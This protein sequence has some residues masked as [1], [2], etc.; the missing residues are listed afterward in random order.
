M[1]SKLPEFFRQ[2]AFYRYHP[3]FQRRERDYKLRLASNFSKSRDLLNSKPSV[4][5]EI[6]RKTFTGKDNN[7]V[8]WHSQADVVSWLRNR[9]KAVSASL[10]NLW[11]SLEPVEARFATF[12]ERLADIGI[13]ASGT[14]LAIAST[15]VMTHSATD[16][17]PVKVGAFRH[18]LEMLGW[19]DLSTKPSA[20]ER[21]LYAR[22]FLDFILKQAPKFKVE[23]RDRLD[24]Q[25]I[26]WCI[27]G[28]WRDTK[29][30]KSWK[31]DVEK[32]ALAEST[33]YHADIVE[34]DAEPNGKRRTP[35]EKLT[36]VK[37][38]RGQGKFRDGVIEVWGNCELS[39]CRDLD[40]LRASHI[41][42]WKVCNDLQRLD[43]FNGLLLSPNFDAVF[44]AGLISFSND[45]TILISKFLTSGD[46][47]ALG[48]FSHLKLRSL[49]KSH[50][51]Y[52]EH[53]RK[54]VFDKKLKHRG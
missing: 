14:Q 9:P 28:G 8:D 2:A 37:A 50:L 21:Y 13:T 34:L 3:L 18:G 40:L 4:A 45:G 27:G 48:L 43:K 5:L 53:H 6:F 25:G 29:V 10:R 49:R 31:N 38:R 35:T 36:L 44:D 24:A 11:E 16:F 41:M 26:L 32:R 39:G 54:H 12:T 42:P 1:N 33:S 7:I 22:S 30:P 52:L 46:R 47:K 17:P 51:F 20:I 15:L 19:E 23:L